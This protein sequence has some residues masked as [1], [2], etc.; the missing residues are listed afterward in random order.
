[1]RTRTWRVFGIVVV[2]SATGWLVA[3]AARVLEPEGEQ[4]VACELRTFD[5]VSFLRV[6]D[7]Q[8]T[9]TAERLAALAS[10]SDLLERREAQYLEVKLQ[11]LDL[12]G[13]LVEQQI[14]KGG[15]TYACVESGYRLFS[16]TLDYPTFNGL[17]RQ[18]LYR[19][20]KRD[21]RDLN[22]PWW[23]TFTQGAAGHVATALVA[24]AGLVLMERRERR[25]EKQ[26]ILV[27]DKLP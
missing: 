9:A 13:P 6:V 27:A 12:L 15:S 4:G 20:W 2:A 24:L 18:E 1:M 16:Y 21:A 26:R 19:L 5:H 23:V 25:K 3:Y 10:T 11:S 8:R 7:A 22:R 17:D 14:R